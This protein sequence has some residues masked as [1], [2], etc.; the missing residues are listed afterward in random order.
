MLKEDRKKASYSKLKL[1]DALFWRTKKKKIIYYLT[2]WYNVH[3]ELKTFLWPLLE[4]FPKSSWITESLG[5]KSVNDSAMSDSLLPR[6]GSPPGSSVHGILQGRI[7]E[8]V[9]IPFS[10]ESSRPRDWTWVFCI[11]GR[12]LTT[13]ATREAQNHQEY[14]VKA[15]I[16]MV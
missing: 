12:F 7:L 14:L 8:W 9:T 5:K 3:S 1:C 2:I 11:A 10:R 6:H 16:S 15:R 13:W 4:W